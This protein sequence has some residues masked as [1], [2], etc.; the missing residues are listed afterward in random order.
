MNIRKQIKVKERNMVNLVEIY[1]TCS[2]IA[3]IYTNSIVCV[4]SD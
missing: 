3:Y 2:C 4:K 1:N